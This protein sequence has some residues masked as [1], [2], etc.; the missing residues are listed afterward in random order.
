MR[1]RRYK[2]LALAASERKLGHEAAAANI[3][4]IAAE[5]PDDSDPRD[6]AALPDA[7]GTP[8]VFYYGCAARAGGHHLYGP[9]VAGDNTWALVDYAPESASPWKPAE[10]DGRLQPN[11]AKYKHSWQVPED[12][13]HL[14]IA[15]LHH[16]AGWTMLSFWDRS[17]DKRHG[18]NG[19]FIIEGTHAFAAAC[20]HAKAAFPGTWRSITTQPGWPAHGELVEVE[21]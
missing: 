8:R 5:L 21:S 1:S 6:T 4:A 16:R 3:E 2:L 12:E 14:G 17:K 11:C 10:I 20:D 13:Q 19:N 15:R 7:V 18:S 9:R